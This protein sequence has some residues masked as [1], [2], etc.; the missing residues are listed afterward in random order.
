[1]PSDISLRRYNR[2]ALEELKLE[3]PL[4]DETTLIRFLSSC[5]SHV[6]DTVTKLRRYESWRDANL[7]ITTASIYN[8]LRTGKAYVRGTDTLGHPLIVFRPYLSD[9]RARDLEAMVR[10]LLFMAEIAIQQMP[11]GCLMFSVLVDRSTSSQPDFEMLKRVSE[12]TDA[13]YPGRLYKVYF[14]PCSLALKGFWQLG[15]RFAPSGANDK[16]RP[17]ASLSALREAIP[18]E[19]IPA[20]LGGTCRYEFCAEDFPS[21]FLNE[22]FY[23]ALNRGAE[24]LRDRAGRGSG[25][26]AD[27]EPGGHGEDRR[28][29]SRERSMGAA[30]GRELG[31]RSRSRSNSD[32]GDRDYRRQYSDD[33][34]DDGARGPMSPSA[35]W[36]TAAKASSPRGPYR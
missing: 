12:L 8:E 27:R 28:R 32:A 24:R 14:Y 25:S 20:V 36:K 19:H 29:G 31:S 30:D 5:S 22:S 35:G 6:G 15:K 33:E 10:L 1:M 3:F 34:L 17:K 21:P 26:D 2:E 16:F 13:N 23:T 18:G 9:P 11:D 7:P 4:I